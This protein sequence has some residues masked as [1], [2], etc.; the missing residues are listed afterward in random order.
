MEVIFETCKNRGI[1]I[2]ESPTGTGK[3]LALLC[4][5]LTW[6]DL[7]RQGQFPPPTV[8]QDLEDEPDWLR[9]SA[10]HELREEVMDLSAELT[11]RKARWMKT[12]REPPPERVAAR[13]GGKHASESFEPED[14]LSE[15]R[16]PSASA[17][18]SSLWG[19][20]DATA[21]LGRIYYAAR[22]H[23]Q[24][25]Q[26]LD[27]LARTAHGPGVSSVALASRAHYCAFEDVRASANPD[28]KCRLRRNGG[29]CGMC[30][31]DAL[32]RLRS[33]VLSQH[34]SI[35][36]AVRAATA[37]A[38]CP[39]YGARSAALVADVVLMPHQLVPVEARRGTFGEG[40]VLIVDE[41]HN[42]PGS[43]RRTREATFSVREAKIAA[44][45]LRA[46]VS[47][48]AGLLSERKHKACLKAVS[49]LQVLGLAFEASRAPG[50]AFVALAVGE[51]LR[52]ACRGNVDL[53]EI[54]ELLAEPGFIP[55]V[56]G[57]GG[58]SVER[59]RRGA[60]AP[61]RSPLPSKRAPVPAL[62]AVTPEVSPT[63]PHS[64]LRALHA[65]LVAVN[66]SD[67]QFDSRAIMHFST[68]PRARLQEGFE[69]ASFVVG[70]DLRAVFEGTHAVVF[71][72]GTLSPIPAFLDELGAPS[73]LPRAYTR[74]LALGH[75][76][77]PERFAVL[78]LGALPGVERFVFN[79]AARGDA[80]L[81]VALWSTLQAIR[82]A[83]ATGGM[84]C[85][86]PSYAALQA[87]R[88]V[89]QRAKAASGLFWEE[90][91]RES[92][93]GKFAATVRAGGTPTLL[94]VIG[95][96]M[97]EGIDFKDD[98]ARCV[99]VV[100]LPFPSPKDPRTVAQRQFLV[101]QRKDPHTHT[102]RG[103][104]QRVNQA[105]G[106]CVRHADDWASCVLLDARFQ[107]PVLR[108][109]ISKWIQP[110]LRSASTPRA[111]LQ[112]LAAFTQRRLECPRAVK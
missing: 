1:S 40:C 51:L 50:R 57:F 59:L 68:A 73:P 80:R 55:K 9:D 14:T 41:A 82:G 63:G 83:V 48:Y 45:T 26:T 28:G 106:R 95:G 107:D 35:D 37:H 56:G 4:A 71:I 11:R 27:E 58:A 112:A 24:L 103:A 2:I 13:S 64:A 5:S 30:G 36:E 90:R 85:F 31:A 42:L 105:I 101:S 88:L 44:W 23:M 47:R 102:Q 109:M 32:R 104:L 17:S 86:F 53:V 7:Y 18:E 25:Q 62:P 49:F 60:R 29:R 92:P 19:E 65:F 16:P 76:I 34:M 38:A 6:L 46:Y 89:A 67:T 10:A 52:R 93:F 3:T 43:L 39:Y 70:E 77:A 91:G 21:R 54:E 79:F 69:I 97:S 75:V 110:S 96:K 61:R 100:G 98:L 94:A 20:K 15:E 33:V 66:A 111:L 74:S 12:A 84:V 72:A 22:T 99:V 81:L 108:A 8:V 87:A 78:S